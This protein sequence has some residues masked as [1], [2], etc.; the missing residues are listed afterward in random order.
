MPG[1]GRVVGSSGAGEEE[2]GFGQF[3]RAEVA[4]LGCWTR[5]LCFGGKSGEYSREIPSFMA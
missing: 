3:L 5:W 4:G 1:L 2:M